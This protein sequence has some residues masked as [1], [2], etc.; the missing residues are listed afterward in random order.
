MQGQGSIIINQRMPLPG[1][2]GITNGLRNGLSIVGGFGELG[3]NPLIHNTD[4]IT[5]A[6]DF[7]MGDINGVSNGTIIQMLN[8]AGIIQIGDVNNV[9]DQ[10][11]IVYSAGVLQFD[12]NLGSVL[13][14]DINNAIY[15]IGDITLINNRTKI[16]VKDASTSIE[17]SAGVGN[18]RITLLGAAGSEQV[19]AELGSSKYIFLNLTTDLYQFG[20]VDG[21]TSGMRLDI[22]ATVPSTVIRDSTADYLRIFPAIPSFSFGDSNGFLILLTAGLFD[23]QDSSTGNRFLELNAVTALYSIGDIDSS[24]NGTQLTVDDF[25][26]QVS[27]IATKGLGINLASTANS[28]LRI[29]GVPAFANNAAAVLAG[30][31]TGEVYRISVAGTSTLAIVE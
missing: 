2:G 13:N 11:R 23:F 8:A 24:L 20:D 6:F 28:P 17:L 9:I 10:S 4:I 26:S 30:L 21:N 18:N 12:Y 29:G 5:D 14:L 31:V 1:S 22:D 16:D 15:Q 25:N 3:L 19:I 7:Q 27:I